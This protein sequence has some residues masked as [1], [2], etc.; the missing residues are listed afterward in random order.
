MDQVKTVKAKTVNELLKAVYKKEGW[1]H[2]G[3]ENRLRRVIAEYGIA[4]DYEKNIYV[5][6]KGGK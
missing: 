3:I 5:A 1:V 6:T 2:D 4:T